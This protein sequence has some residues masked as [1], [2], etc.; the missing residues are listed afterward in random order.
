MLSESL[1]NYLVQAAV[2]KIEEGIDPDP[3]AVESPEAL[4]CFND[5]VKE[6]QE[7]IDKYG[8]DEFHK[9]SWDVGYDY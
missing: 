9:V 8:I 1:R 3:E 2:D 4:K 7:Y 6:M 5:T